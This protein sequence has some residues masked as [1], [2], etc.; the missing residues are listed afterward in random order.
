MQALTVKLEQLRKS[1]E[2]LEAHNRM[3]MAA[4][5][6]HGIAV[7][8]SASAQP[9]ATGTPAMTDVAG[10]SGAQG[11]PA[12]GTG[13]GMYRAAGM[14][15]TPGMRF[16]RTQRR[17][18]IDPANMPAPISSSEAPGSS[19]AAEESRC[20]ICLCLPCIAC[21]QAG[22]TTNILKRAQALTQLQGS[23]DHTHY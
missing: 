11:P 17:T 20:E 9:H 6:Q 16:L 10:P 22:Q 3:L 1:E 4:L 19:A 18:Q 8:Q 21:Q 23:Q 14:L 13:A 15:D 2:R 12:A 5:Q 7:P